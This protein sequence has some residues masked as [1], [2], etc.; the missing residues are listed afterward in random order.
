MNTPESPRHRS[1][2]WPIV[3]I[4]AGVILLLAN[5][6]LITTANLAALSALWPL[7]LVALGLEILFGRR[8]TLASG[9]IG[10]L[11][12][13][14]FIFI[15]VAGQKLGLNLPSAQVIQE[16]FNEPMGSTRSA[17]VLVDI[18]S[19][20][21]SI[22]ALS[23]S[24]N[25]FDA[26]VTHFG[27]MEFK[28]SGSSEKSIELRKRPNTTT[29]TW[30]LPTQPTRWDISLSPDVPLSLKLIGGSGSANADLSQLQI[31]DLQ[32]D[33]ASGSFSV[34]LPESAQAY[35]ANFEGGS[36]SLRV[37][38]PANTNMTLSIDGASGS[39]S[40]ELP[41]SAEVRIEV[42]DS[43]SG[44]LN[45]PRGL[46]QVE[47]GNGDEG[48]WETAGYANATQRILIRVQDIGSG[49]LNIN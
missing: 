29:L 34:A 43:G 9:L 16:R 25:L 11:V 15:L 44:S 41:A 2:F 40:L 32:V 1:I 5:F 18:A 45:L 37:T 6:N 39:I 19:D 7:L 35:E 10:L 42:M 48:I 24:T 47:K 30:G 23:G 38:L 22:N 12:V 26:N 13:G 36:G 33:V 27:E 3:L 46:T 14:A 21:V 8:S 4:G 17:N 28:V 49:S 20:P 31:E